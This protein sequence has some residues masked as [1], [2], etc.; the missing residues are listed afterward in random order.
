M[1]RKYVKLNIISALLTLA[2]IVSAVTAMKFFEGTRYCY[3]SAFVIIIAACVPFFISF[4]RRKPSARELV[5][6][7]S[8]CAIAVASR[9]AF[10]AIPTVKPICAVIIITAACFGAQTGFVAGAVSMFAS[11][12]IFGQGVFT[13]F[14]MLALGAVGFAAGVI[15]SNK[16][17]R[18][19]RPALSL[20]GGVLCFVIYGLIVDISSV[21]M[22]ATSFSIKQILAIYASGV[23][24]NAS[25][26]AMSRAVT[27]LGTKP[28]LLLIDGNRFRSS[29]D[30]PYRCIV[31][32][33]ASYAPIASVLAKTYRDEYMMR[34]A[35]EYPVYKWEQNKGYPTR[36]HR[37]AVMRHGLSP[38]HRLSFN[39]SFKQLELFS[40]DE[41]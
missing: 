25:F 35:A 19:S 14:Q 12:F 37:E 2:L 3:I 18:E 16:R 8:M 29:L 23:P 26:A 13:P 31:K 15:F 9:A 24:F 7:A 41:K 39:H 22:M 4:E 36:E 1:Q 21:L 6:L 32:G 38:Y 30:I 17:L 5:A 10:F 28:Q 34:I 33:D 27:K 40:L 11:N 20:I